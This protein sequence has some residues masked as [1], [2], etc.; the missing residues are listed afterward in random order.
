MLSLSLAEI[1]ALDSVSRADLGACIAA[2]ALGVV[3][4]GEIVLDLNCASWAGILALLAA[5][6]GSLARLY[7]YRAL[8][9][10]AACD[11]CLCVSRNKPD[12]K[13]RTCLCAH[14]AAGALRRVNAGN[15]VVVVNSAAGADLR[16]VAVAKAAEEH[17]PSPP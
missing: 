3:D 4:F 6:A 11:Y 8:V 16:A 7:G 10:A 15:A 14:S 9:L 2:H 1:Y 13:A 5:Y 17:A 12:Y